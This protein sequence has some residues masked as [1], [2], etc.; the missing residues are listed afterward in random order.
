MGY[1]PFMLKSP[2]GK[3][4]YREWNCIDPKAVL[5]LVHGMGGYSGRFFE[6]G[7]Y[8]AR[9][10]F[11]IYAIEQRGHGENPTPK[12]HIDNFKVY[13][14]DLK[15][16]VEFA[17]KQNPGK[18]IFVFGE[19]M[20]GLITLDFAIHHQ[21][22]IDGIILMS[23]AVKDKLP[24]T[25]AKKVDIFLSS[26]F[27]PMKYFSAQFDAG[28]FTRDKVVAKRINS[29]PLELRAFTAKF[30]QAILKTMIYVNLMPH[31]I[32]LP[33]F[34]ILGGNDLMVDAKAGEKYFGKLSSKDKTLKWYL[35]MYHALYVDKDREQIFK[36]MIDWMNKRSEKS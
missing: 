34:M 11:Q 35:D 12:G 3:V 17:K 15:T 22:L 23:P 14:Q 13:A 16:L 2:D 25:I 31:S 1:N 33:V 8:I 4:F 18:K 30:Y 21:K 32:K 10:H 27:N 36:D 9:S 26:I 19:S 24:M 5:I 6:M 20:G 28:M 29:D 7:P